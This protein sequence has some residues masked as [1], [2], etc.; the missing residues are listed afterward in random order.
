MGVADRDWCRE[1][2]RPKE[3][4]APKII[5]AV[6]A[7]AGLVLLVAHSR[8]HAVADP[9]HVVHHE[10]SIG[11]GHGLGIPI[12]GAP[13]Y[14]RNDPWKKYLA[15]DHTCP[16][17]ENVDVLVNVQASS[18]ICLINFARQQRGLNPLPVSSK[19][20][21]AARLK[22]EAIARCRVFAHAPCGGDPH[23]VAVQAGYTV[24]SWGENILI[25]DGPWAAPR[26]ALD[27]WLNSPG[28]RE[29]LFRPEWRVQSIYVV[30]LSSFPGFRSPTLWV[31]EF[32]DRP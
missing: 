21:V 14:A 25:A 9:E 28:H 27:G 3:S 1:Q 19:L 13:L 29:N 17:A 8:H 2:P 32:G 18:M 23:D 26:P 15:D 4:L 16:A 20:T 24:G 7:V 6:L 22:G 12:K 10:L 11:A 30:K 31:S 5:L